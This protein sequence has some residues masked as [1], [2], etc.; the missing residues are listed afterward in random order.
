MYMYMYV[1]VLRTL[2]VSAE[3]TRN[4]HAQGPPFWCVYIC[5]ERDRS[6]D[7]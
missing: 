5:T 4:A 7:R 1:S 6:I 2:V 3:I